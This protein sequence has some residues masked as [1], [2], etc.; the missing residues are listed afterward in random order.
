MRAEWDLYGVFS[1][2]FS[3]KNCPNEC[4]FMA[5]RV[6]LLCV[7]FTVGL[8]AGR[9]VGKCI[10]STA[11]Q[12]VNNC[13]CG[14]VVFRIN[15][16]SIQYGRVMIDVFHVFLKWFD[17]VVVEVDGYSKYEDGVLLLENEYWWG[18]GTQYLL[19]RLSV[20]K[21][22]YVNPCEGNRRNFISR[23]EM[24]VDLAS[25]VWHILGTL[26]RYVMLNCL[27]FNGIR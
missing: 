16:H 27:D 3:L 20:W 17:A 4:E 6:F 7:L 1:R 5:P 24:H 15:C 14:S 9:S 2:S 19:D 22:G 13:K 25:T 26:A 11:F 21:H 8:L 12:L 18:T 10:C 23:R